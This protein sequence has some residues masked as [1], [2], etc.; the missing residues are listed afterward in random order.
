MV[1][2]GFLI[3]L[4][5]LIPTYGLSLL[6]YFGIIVARGMFKA[7]ARMHH[8]NKQQALRD[9]VEASAGSPESTACTE[10]SWIGDRDEEEIFSAVLIKAC[11]RKGIPP[12][13][14]KGLCAQP[15]FRQLLMTFIGSLESQGSSFIQQQMEAADFIEM[16]W[17]RLSEENKSLIREAS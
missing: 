2:I 11:A 10:P 5:F 13:Y 17:S 14:V 9:V 15:E 8:A 7:N 1:V 4:V 3:A 12:L 6:V 16:A